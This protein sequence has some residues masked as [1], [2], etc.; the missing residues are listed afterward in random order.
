MS[1]NFINLFN[2][3]TL[4]IPSL[5]IIGIA[6]DSVSN[7]C[8]NYST[9]CTADNQKYLK[10]SASSLLVAAGILAFFKVLHTYKSI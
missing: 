7:S 1:T 10:I 9:P 4:L 2:M 8:T 6:L 5:F 3:L